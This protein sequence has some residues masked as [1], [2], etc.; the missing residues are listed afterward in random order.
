M[1]SKPDHPARKVIEDI[2]ARG[3]WVIH[4]M[5]AMNFYRTQTIPTNLHIDTISEMLPGVAT[6]P[7]WKWNAT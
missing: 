1:A 2:R 3:L 5:M 4:V 6:R 7:C